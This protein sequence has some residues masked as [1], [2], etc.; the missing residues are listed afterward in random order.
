MSDY[1]YIKSKDNPNNGHCRE[2]GLTEAFVTEFEQNVIKQLDGIRSRLWWIALW[3][4][5]IFVT[6]PSFSELKR[7]I[8][9]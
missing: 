5:F 2:A 1:L 9:H 3:T 7:L 4:W 6:I 8:S